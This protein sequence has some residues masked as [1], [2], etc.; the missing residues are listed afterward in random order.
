MDVGGDL[1]GDPLNLQDDALVYAAKGFT[2]NGKTTTLPVQY[3]ANGTVLRDNSGK[4]LLVPNALTVATGYTSIAGP[5]KDY[6]GVNPPTIISP[7]TIDIPVYADLLNQT[8]NSRVQSG[9]PEVIFNAQ[10]SLNNASNWATKFPAGGTATQPTVVH[11]I[12]GGLNIPSNAVLKNR[13]SS[14]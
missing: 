6:A 7:Q 11:V 3:N 1:D 12:N 4:A 5:S 14:T 2:I 9:T 13:N 10:T 8:L